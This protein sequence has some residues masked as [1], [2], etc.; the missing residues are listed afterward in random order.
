MSGGF[1]VGL[2][3]LSMGWLFFALGAAMNFHCWRKAL[4]AREGERV[5]SGVPFLPGVAGSLSAFFT[6]PALASLGYELVWP[7]L[8]ILAPLFLDVYCLGRFVLA[9][10]GFARR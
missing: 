7:W 5:P 10:L 6:L 3:L 8:W 1:W 4:A 2:I 9:L